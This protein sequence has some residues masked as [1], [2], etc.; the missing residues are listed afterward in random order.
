MKSLLQYLKAYKKEVVL[1]PLFKLLEAIFE[2]FVPLVVAAIIDVGIKENDTSYIAA[3]CGIMI[4]L[5]VIGLICAISAQFFAARAAVGFSAKIKQV[6]F[7]HIQKFSY[8]DLDTLGTSSLITNMTSDVNQVQTGVNL[9]LRL[10]LRSPVIVFGAMIM[11]FTIDVKSAI[12]FV[13]LIPALSVVVFGIMLITIPLYKKV[14]QR[15]DKL[16]GITRENLNGVRVIRAFNRRDAEVEVFRE[17][18]QS[19]NAIQVFVGKISA[20][21]NPLTFILVNGAIIILIR[22]GA[23]QVNTGVISQGELIALYN[24]MSQIL[25]ELVKLAN[26]IIT[27]TKATASGNRIQAVL[28]EV[29]E[30]HKQTDFDEDKTDAC[31]IHFENVSMTYKHAGAESL[32]NIS[33]S[34]AH[35]QTLGIIGSTGS[36]KSTLVNLIPRFY[37]ATDGQITVDGKPID[38]YTEQELRDKIGVVAQK[39]VLFKGTVRSNL[40]WG[41]STADEAV[42]TEALT[43]AQAYDFVMDKPGGLDAEV[44]QGGKNFSG[45]QRQ[46]LCIARALVKRPDILILDDSSSALDFATDASLRK[47]IRALPYHPTTVIVSQRTASIMHADVIVVL[48]DG[49][50]AGVGT[51]D[52]L[53]QSCPVYLEIYQSQFSENGGVSK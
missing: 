14:Q 36:G 48:D 22:N 50:L 17:A 18:N 24:Y 29:P 19:L 38:S 41:D 31:A 20:L 3:C 8:T 28:N 6:L 47:A 16:L 21:M 53:M 35:G 5:G 26:L 40:C 27:I 11:A 25:V 37:P 7:D 49:E 10:F 52:E 45:G 1:S 9:V 12:P 32:S 23:F 44:E 4:L 43:A 34:V 42:L 51:H 33:F 30:K 13:V 2:L 46:R 15:L 39:N